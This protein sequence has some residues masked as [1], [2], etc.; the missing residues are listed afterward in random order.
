MSIAGSFFSSV[1]S[2]L[3]DPPEVTKGANEVSKEGS[4]GVGTDEGYERSS[5]GEASRASG[6]G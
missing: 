4:N 1:F 2:A 6:M 5:R 3:A